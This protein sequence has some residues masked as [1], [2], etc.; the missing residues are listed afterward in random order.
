[1]TYHAKDGGTSNERHRLVLVRSG[2]GF[3]IADDARS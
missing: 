1:L 3:L 2:G